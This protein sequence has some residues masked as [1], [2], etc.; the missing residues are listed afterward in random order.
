MAKKATVQQLEQQHKPLSAAIL[1]AFYNGEDAKKTSEKVA[2][3]EGSR[4]SYLFRHFPA[5]DLSTIKQAIKEMKEMAREEHGD[6]SPQLKSAQNRAGD[7]QNLYGAWRFGQF[8]PDGMGY[9]DAVSAA[10]QKLQS[11]KIKW[12]GDRQPEEWEKDVR[13][14]VEAEANVLHAAEMERE[15]YKRAHNG[16]EPSAEQLQQFRKDAQDA[17]KKSGAVSMARK[18][19]EKNG[20]EFCGWLID[21]LE[22][23]IAAGAEEEPEQVAKVA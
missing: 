16:E 5:S 21:A 6:K 14:R 4:L 9:T 8:K 3:I 13:K 1:L 23:A 2:Q 20:A 15:K 10:R 17:L 22:G 12:T 18:L 19:Y 11:M 7:I